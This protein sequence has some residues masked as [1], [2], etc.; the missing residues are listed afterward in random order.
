MECCHLLPTQAGL[1]N[2]R[3]SGLGRSK[4]TCQEPHVGGFGET[5]S[6]PKTSFATSA[7]KIPN[8]I[9]ARKV[10][11]QKLGSWMNGFI[12]QPNPS[13]SHW[14]ATIWKSSASTPSPQQ[15]S[16]LGRSAE[17]SVNGLGFWCRLKGLG[18]SRGSGLRCS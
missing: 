4:P 18:D 1:L 12:H 17:F 13:C 7:G 16:G 3:P 9:A 5:S 15:G 6:L 11:D 8:A 10:T 2:E 14:S